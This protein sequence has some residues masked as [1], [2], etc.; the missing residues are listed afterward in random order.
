MSERRAYEIPE[1]AS[2]EVRAWIERAQ[3]RLDYFAGQPKYRA[4]YER[5]GLELMQH[6]TLLSE[7]HAEGHAEGRAE[8]HAEGR[9]E[10]LSEGLAK[11]LSK[12]RT[13]GRTEGLAEGRA[14]MLI[15]SIAGMR[16]LA[17]TDEQIIQALKLTP[18]EVDTYLK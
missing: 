2:P 11:G 17:L 7:R 9:A 12:G 14:I 6:N 4:A 8:G 18:D 16:E 5:E 10:G 1:G 13:E 3:A 15:A